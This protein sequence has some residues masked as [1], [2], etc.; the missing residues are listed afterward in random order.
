MKVIY[1]SPTAEG[2]GVNAVY[3]RVEY[4]YKDKDKLLPPRFGTNP[5]FGSYGRI[6]ITVTWN[7]SIEGGNKIYQA[8]FNPEEASYWMD[9]YRTDNNVSD[10]M[11][12]PA[13]DQHAT[14]TFTPPVT[15]PNAS[16]VAPE[17][18]TN[19]TL[20]VGEY[21]FGEKGHTF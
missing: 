3:P 15:I 12:I 18:W 2:A 10:T 16:P 13:P 5:Q 4:R 19:Q 20:T 14:G 8:V 1:D 17:N 11:F 9:F 7:Y 6:E 21:T